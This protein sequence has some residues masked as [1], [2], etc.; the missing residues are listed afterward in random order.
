MSS[1]DV[2]I[3][4][5]GL[6]GCSIARALSLA[7]LQTLNVDRLPAA[8]YGSTSH[9]SA[10]IR[11]FYSHVTSCAIAH[12]ARSCWL[13]W[14]ELLELGAPA[15][16]AEYRETGGL[17]LIKAGEEQ[18][19]DANLAAL[20]EVGVAYD[21]ID[22]ADLTR[23][24]PGISL[25][26]FG[27]PKPMTDPGFGAPT[28]G[29]IS[30]AIFIPACGHV[31]DPQLAAANLAAA[32]AA[33]GGTFKF[34]VKVVDFLRHDGRVTGI[35]LDNGDRLQASL[36]INAAGPHSAAV[37]AMAGISAQMP[38]GTS[39]Q[40]HEVAYVAA[41]AEHGGRDTGLLVDLD[42]GYYA[43]RDGADLLI[44]TAD[45][46]CD[47]ADVVDPEDY[48][49]S[50]TEQWTLQVYRAAQRMP[51]LAIESRARGTV[52]LYDVSDD[53]IP[54]YD[55]SDLP[56]YLLAIGTSGNQ[57]KNAPL[58]GDIMAAIVMAELNGIDH[59]VSPQSL[60]LPHL[61]RKVD[62]SFFSRNRQ[63]QATASVMA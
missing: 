56:G 9:S 50:F 36:V 58:I 44:G 22:A 31:S 37:N 21:L 48:S 57:F 24:L 40:R 49:D 61:D 34:G 46:A 52:G 5:A 55:K 42:A 38:I 45:P 28:T 51:G 18:Q 32:A 19:F 54:I 6:V 3:I 23:R 11:P 53:W 33:A 35:V 16:L 60:H 43:R 7:G 15:A 39:A 25:H 63:V 10:I 8:G 12:E 14:G 30:G 41:P 17:V 27:P 62:L 26:S 1:A 20:D 4:G 2:V 59:D 47:A 29:D 13:R